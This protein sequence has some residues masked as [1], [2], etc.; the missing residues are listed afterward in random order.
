MTRTV[1]L[2]AKG[3]QKD[4]CRSVERSNQMHS[5]AMVCF[6]TL[7]VKL[8]KSQGWEGFGDEKEL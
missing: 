5:T 8:D 2:G 3:M 7:E 6:E 1:T 4:S